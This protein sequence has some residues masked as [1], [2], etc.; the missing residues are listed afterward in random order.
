MADE[1]GLHVDLQALHAAFVAE[2]R[3]LDPAERGLGRRDAE[4]V[5][6]HHAGLQRVGDLGRHRPGTSLGRRAR[7][8]FMKRHIDSA[9]P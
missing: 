2:A 7:G 9:A 5:D 1:L 6:G 4:V 3:I 8:D